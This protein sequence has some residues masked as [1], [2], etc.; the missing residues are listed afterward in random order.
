MLPHHWHF[1][2]VFNT[3]LCV[4]G[5]LC[6]VLYIRLLAS[7]QLTRIYNLNSRSFKVMFVYLSMIHFGTVILCHCSWWRYG[8][9][10]SEI[11]QHVQSFLSRI[12]AFDNWKASFNSLREH[13]T[14]LF[15]KGESVARKYCYEKC[16]S[17]L[18]LQQS[19]KSLYGLYV[20]GFLSNTS[21]NLFHV[22]N[23]LK[24]ASLL[25]FYDSTRL[26]AVGM[27]KGITVVDAVN[28]V[29]FYVWNF[30]H[31]LL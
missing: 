8:T 29:K 4:R 24:W 22:D 17:S 5:N 16:V 26:R 12:F 2:R 9:A 11:F 25:N 15:E 20:R 27:R 31:L 18:Y 30:D 13:A 1:F 14:A 19:H 28:D 10:S 6:V 21:F 23:H 3:F 7:T